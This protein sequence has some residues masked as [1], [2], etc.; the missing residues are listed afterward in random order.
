MATL[1]PLLAS[2]A[3]RLALA[4]FRRLGGEAAPELRE[5]ILLRDAN[6]VGRRFDAG[7][8]FAI[9]LI[10]EEQLNIYDRRGRQVQQ[11]P[12]AQRPEPLRRAA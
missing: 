3:R 1:E 11:I 6:Y 5:T 10:D 9:W 2:E 7:H 12:I 4:A 8:G